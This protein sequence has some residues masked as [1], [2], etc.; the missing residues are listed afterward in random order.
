MADGSPDPS[1]AA[2]LQ[3]RGVREVLDRS[4]EAAAIAAG[5]KAAK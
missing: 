4:Q 1:I 3:R 2:A 5:W